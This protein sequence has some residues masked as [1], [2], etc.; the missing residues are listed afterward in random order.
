MGV[1]AMVAVTAKRAKGAKFDAK[2][3]RAKNAAKRKRYAKAW[4]AQHREDEIAKAL[5]RY[6]SDPD[7]GRDYGRAYY[8]ENREKIL[9]AK[10]AR[11]R[12]RGAKL[13]RPRT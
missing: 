6:R 9:A 7:R 11:R 1:T 5:A 12:K 4:Y 8:A 2:K 13:Y 10:R 3:W